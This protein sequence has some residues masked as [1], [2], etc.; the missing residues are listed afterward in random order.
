MANTFLL[1]RQI[2]G[3]GNLLNDET[4]TAN[5]KKLKVNAQVTAINTLAEMT[6]TV[7]YIII[8]AIMRG[9]NFYVFMY[10]QFFSSILF[11]FTFLS[12][13]SENKDRIL[14]VGWKNV[15]KNIIDNIK[16]QIYAYLRIVAETFSG[17]DIGINR[18]QTMNN[19]V[20]KQIVSNNDSQI[21]PEINNEISI[22]RFKQDEITEKPMGEF[23]LFSN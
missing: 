3:A 6:F 12:N 7:T 21:K 11:P 16:N 13:T 23:K 14:E 22:S 8:L 2:G 9:N 1:S 18:I 15:V 5:M 19:P 10:I 20:S 17:R 4:N